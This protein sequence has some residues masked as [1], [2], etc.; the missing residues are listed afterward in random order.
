[1]HWAS[2]EEEYVPGVVG[3]AVPVRI[4]GPF[5]AGLGAAAPSIRFHRGR[6]EEVLPLLRRSANLLA[7]SLAHH[8]EV[9]LGP[10]DTTSA[11]HPVGRAVPRQGTVRPSQ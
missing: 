8:N 4:D 2:N 3:C 7:D 6:V 10:S 9:M 11:A 1:M 5:V